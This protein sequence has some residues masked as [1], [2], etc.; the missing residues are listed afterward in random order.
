MC[1]AYRRDKKAA[2]LSSSNRT[3]QGAAPDRLQS[4]PFARSL[5][6][7]AAGELVVV[8]SRAALLVCDN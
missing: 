7:S 1:K 4:A 6:L 8:P 2:I 3:Q 5:S